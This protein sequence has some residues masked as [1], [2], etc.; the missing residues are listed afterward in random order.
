MLINNSKPADFLDTVLCRL[1][2]S[3]HAMIWCTQFPIQLMSMHGQIG[4]IKLTN[5][6]SKALRYKTGNKTGSLQNYNHPKN[7][8]SRQLPNGT[9]GI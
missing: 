5:Q 6:A 2:L 9:S 1:T 4:P 7:L 8:Q 3:M